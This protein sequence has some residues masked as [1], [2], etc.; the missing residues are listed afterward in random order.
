MTEVAIGEIQRYLEDTLFEPGN[1][2]P[3]YIFER[4]SYARWAAFELLNRLMDHPTEDPV[5][6]V[7]AFMVEM[8]IYSYTKEDDTKK[9]FMFSTARDVAENVLYLLV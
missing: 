8:D 3:S 1:D 9:S 6:I 4:R 7:E 2:W 5:T